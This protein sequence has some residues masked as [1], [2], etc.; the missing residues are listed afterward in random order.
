MTIP[1]ST[2]KNSAK[3]RGLYVVGNFLIAGRSSDVISGLALD[4]TPSSTYIWTFIVPTYDDLFMHMSLGERVSVCEDDSECLSVAHQF[5]R[6]S[7][8]GIRTAGDLI[9]YIERKNF[10]GEYP[11]WAR[12]ISLIRA[13]DFQAADSVFS[14]F[15]SLRISN[16]I[17]EKVSKVRGVQLREGWAAAALLLKEWSDRTDELLYDIPSE[18]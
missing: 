4:K 9:K 11:Y 14:L 15:L 16:S 3:K 2:I 13:G 1:I 8:G 12:Y 5:Y 10:T 7:L 18:I 6:E 17:R